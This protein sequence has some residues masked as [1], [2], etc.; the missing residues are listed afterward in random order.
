MRTHYLTTGVARRTDATI[1]AGLIAGCGVTDPDVA[2][3]LTDRAEFIVDTDAGVLM[4]HVF[5]SEETHSTRYRS[6]GWL[7]FRFN[8][9]AQA[10]ACPAVSQQRLNPYSGKYNFMFTADETTH[11]EE[12]EE[13]AAALK[14]LNARNLYVV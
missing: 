2:K 1:I 4:G 11:T 10:K 12:V 7:A 14:R 6:P 9:T 13:M 5:L 3:L 8:S